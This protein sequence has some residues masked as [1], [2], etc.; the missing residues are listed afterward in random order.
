MMIVHLIVRR[1][2][3]VRVTPIPIEYVPVDKGALAIA[4]S[5]I[6]GVA[7]SRSPSVFQSYGDRVRV[8]DHVWHQKYDFFFHSYARV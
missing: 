8:R 4:V 5:E 3:V 1:P 7:F 2:A 6:G